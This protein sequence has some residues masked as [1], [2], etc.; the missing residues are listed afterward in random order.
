MTTVWDA[1][2]KSPQGNSGSND[3]VVPKNWASGAAFLIPTID[4]V[5]SGW[6]PI[7]A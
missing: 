5:I 4:G 2:E 6:D 3:F 1:K 7:D